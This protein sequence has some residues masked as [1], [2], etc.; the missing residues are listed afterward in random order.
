MQDAG[1]ALDAY[2]AARF[3]ITLE[4]LLSDATAGRAM[5]G[6]KGAVAVTCDPVGAFVY[7]DGGASEL[8][9][10]ILTVEGVVYRFRCSV[11]TDAGGARFVESIG[12]LETVR[13]GV[14]LAI[15]GR[16]AAQSET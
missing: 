6:A 12:D 10:G 1:D 8:F 13:W 3:G 15:P 9:Q 16:T 7:E 4:R 5:V 2:M 11:F 14:R